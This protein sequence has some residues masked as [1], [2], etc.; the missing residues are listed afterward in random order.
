[1]EAKKAENLLTAQNKLTISMNQYNVSFKDKQHTEND[2]NKEISTHCS[3]LGLDQNHAEMIKSRIN[4][5]KKDIALDKDTIQQECGW[6]NTLPHNK[7]GLEDYTK[8]TNDQDSI[9]KGVFDEFKEKKI[10]ELKVDLLSNA[11]INTYQEDYLLTGLH[12][13]MPNWDTNIYTSPND[14]D[15][16]KRKLDNFVKLGEVSPV[17]GEVFLKFYSEKANEFINPKTKW[18]RFVEKIT[19]SSQGRNT[20]AP[21]GAVGKQSQ[22]SEQSVGG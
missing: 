4:Q 20:I 6:L 19:K 1:V 22:G 14:Y 8:Y 13:E 11:P 10:Y 17:E 7:Q 15:Q 2:I 21:Q 9:I 5:I 3:T 12:Q 16:L 18:Q